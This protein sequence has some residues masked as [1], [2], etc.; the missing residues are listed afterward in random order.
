MNEKLDIIAIGESLIELSSDNH[1]GSADSL[2][3]YYGGDALSVAVAARRMGSNV[4]FVSRVGDDVF[5]DYL[6]D[7]WQAEG[8]DIS[9]V[10]I[11]QEQNGVYFIARPDGCAKEFAYYRKKIAPSKLSLDDISED[12]ISSAK[13]V[14]ASGITQSLSLS[15]KEVVAESFKIA[16]KNGIIT[17]YD[18]NYSSS[19]STPEIAK[20]DFNRVISD[21]DILFMSAKY[22]TVNILELNSVENLIKKMWDLGVGTVVIKA[23]PDGGYYTGYNGN[24]VFTEFYTHDVVDT[25]C[26]GDAFNGGFLHA[27]THGLTPIEAS[28]FASI[29]AGLQ[30]KSI[31]A[32]KSIP[33]KEQ[34]Y[35]IFEKGVLNG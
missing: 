29:V 32:I 26:S 18:P 33:Y 25:T 6:L 13:V 21:V 19:I 28:K 31:G 8:L 20:E 23:S 12:Y 35:D 27:I 10:K 4:G 14:Y 17:A 3:K 9:Q 34:V 11:A 15:A 2:K 5:K 24:I 1:L 7:S 22:D 16:K 30:A